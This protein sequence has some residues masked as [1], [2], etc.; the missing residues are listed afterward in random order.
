[1]MAGGFCGLPFSPTSGSGRYVDAICPHHSKL[2][3]LY[4]AQIILIC[5]LPPRQQCVGDEKETMSE[6]LRRPR[7][8]EHTISAKKHDIFLS[9]DEVDR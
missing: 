1:M 4:H 6:L 5:P 7:T 9:F 3:C 8:T 2:S